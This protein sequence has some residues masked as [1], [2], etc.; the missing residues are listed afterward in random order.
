MQRD[1]QRC[2]ERKRLFLQATHA[3]KLGDEWHAGGLLAVSRENQ[4]TVVNNN[5]PLEK[6][7]VGCGAQQNDDA[8]LL[9]H[10]RSIILE[11]NARAEVLPAPLPRWGADVD[12]CVAIALRCLG[13]PS[14]GGVLS[15]CECHGGVVWRDRD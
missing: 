14:L 3:N 12:V 7:K 9:L 10:F 1:A 2:G 8:L 4:E 15:V 13:V 5:T 6:K 11:C